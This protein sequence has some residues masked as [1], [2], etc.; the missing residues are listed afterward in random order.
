M[1]KLDHKAFDKMVLGMLGPMPGQTPTA[2]GVTPGLQII[3]QA[4]MNMQGQ[5]AQTG[6]L[7]GQETDIFRQS[8]VELE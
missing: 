1:P 8:Q 4:I 2:G 6:T 3:R 5:G 7:M